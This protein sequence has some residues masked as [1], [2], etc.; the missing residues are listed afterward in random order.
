[1]YAYIVGA[2][3]GT[4]QSCTL[5]QYGTFSAYGSG[6]PSG[7]Y[8]FEYAAGGLRLGQNGTM[9][10]DANGTITFVP[11]GTYTTPSYGKEF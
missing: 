4:P 5:Q 3:K 2:G 8:N 9:T 10:T 6:E 7:L 1:M 11:D